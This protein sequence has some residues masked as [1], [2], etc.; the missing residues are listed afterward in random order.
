VRCITR[1]TSYESRS[2]VFRL[3]VIADTHLGNLHADEATLRETAREIADDPRHYWIH[4]GDVA[5]F[6]NL[7]DPRFDP[8]ELVGWL[9]GGE[10][11]AD[12][13]RAE[14]RRF[15]DIMSPIRDRCLGL[16]EGNHEA[17]ILRHSET[18]VYST[19]I[20]GLAADDEHRLDHRGFISWRFSRMGG[21]GWTCNLYATHGS[22]GGRSGGAAG[23]R[24]AMLASQVDGVD[25]VLM[26][27]MHRPE[28]QPF[29]KMRPG[30]RSH[31]AAT[32]HAISAPALCGDMAYADSKDMSAVPTGIVVVTIDPN[33]H[34]VAGVDVRLN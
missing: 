32:V 28:Y 26:G 18:D 25:L 7:R 22:G 29:S 31:E 4:L 21:G 30:K 14:T 3:Y 23:N 9:C 27:H 24:L 11:L 17:A 33:E 16:C 20:E 5:E 34:R 12:I 10:A 8:R 15:L 1:R 6:I 13:G 19:L 2:D